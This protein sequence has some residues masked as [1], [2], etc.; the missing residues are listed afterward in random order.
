MSYLYSKLPETGVPLLIGTGGEAIQSQ[1]TL[2]E[3]FQ[4]SY[5]N[6]PHHQRHYLRHSGNCL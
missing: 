1:V 6:A 4:H 3:F 5:V 2:R